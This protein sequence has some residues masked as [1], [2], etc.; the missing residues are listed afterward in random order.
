MR[1]CDCDRAVPA[2]CRRSDGFGWSGHQV[3][4]LRN[5]R[6]GSTCSAAVSGPRLHTLIWIRMSSGAGL[7]VFDE[8]I[9]VAILVEY[10]GI[11]QFIFQVVA[12]APPVVSTRSP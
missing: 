9:E 7:R 11:E 6:V 1:R 3:Q 4:V 8:H 12:T 10:A 5:H 2:A